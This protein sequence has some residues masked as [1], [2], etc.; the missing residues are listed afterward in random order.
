M[1]A[2]LIREEK[3]VDLLHGPIEN[4]FALVD[5]DGIA[6]FRKLKIAGRSILCQL[7]FQLVRFTG[8]KMSDPIGLPVLSRDIE[9]FTHCD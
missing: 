6:V 9:V 1:Q 2:R 8:T 7:K 4:Q 3:E 5:A